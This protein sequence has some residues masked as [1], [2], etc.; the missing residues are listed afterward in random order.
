VED[1]GKY[2]SAEV[3]RCGGARFYHSLILPF[4]YST[5]QSSKLKVHAQDLAFTGKQ[6]RQGNP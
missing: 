3:W 5:I 6:N 1:V 2:E 4:Y